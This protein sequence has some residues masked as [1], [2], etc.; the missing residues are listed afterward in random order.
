MKGPI[1]KGIVYFVEKFSRLLFNCETVCSNC[2]S[3]IDRSLARGRG[4]SAGFPKKFTNTF[5]E[6]FIF[7]LVYK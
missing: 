2:C 1:L 3:I 5:L 6:L 7:S 4:G